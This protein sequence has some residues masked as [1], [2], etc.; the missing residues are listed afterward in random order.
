MSQLEESITDREAEVTFANTS[1]KATNQINQPTRVLGNVCP[2]PS[3]SKSWVFEG[4]YFGLIH[5]K[6]AKN[7]IICS[8]C[9]PIDSPDPTEQTVKPVNWHLN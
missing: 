1:L 7:K 4:R 5:E 6:W 3:K 8:L 9:Y 2:V